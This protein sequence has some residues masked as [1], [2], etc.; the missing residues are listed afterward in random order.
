MDLNANSIDVVQNYLPTNLLLLL[1]LVLLLSTSGTVS[2]I[3]GLA[4]MKHDL[5]QGLR[6]FCPVPNCQC[7]LTSY[8]V[9][10]GL[11]YYV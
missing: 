6:R 9:S 1:L 7:G 10:V 8:R 11:G 2:T 4:I 5:V 3:R